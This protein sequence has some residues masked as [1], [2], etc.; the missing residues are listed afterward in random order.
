MLLLI[1]VVLCIVLVVIVGTWLSRSADILAEKTGLGR[2]LVGAIL[3][4]GVTSLPELATGISAV[5]VFNAPDLAAGGIFGSCLFNLF[6]LALLDIVTGPEP[7]FQRAH[8]SH[9]LAAGLGSILL[10]IAAAGMLLAQSNYNLT[11][12]WVGIPSIL[13]FVVYFQST[14]IIAQFERR[15]RAEVLEVEAEVFQYEH[16]KRQQAYLMFGLLSAAIV[17][18]GVWL[19]FLGDRV[20]AVTGLGESFI[21]ALLLAATTSLPEV[22]AGL[23]AIR[24]NAVDL[25]VSNIFGSNIFNMAILGVYDIAYFRGDLWSHISSVHIFTAIVALIMTSV[26]IVGLI[27]RAVRPSRLYISWDGLSL[28]ALYIGGM[29]IIYRS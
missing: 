1:Q 11:L 29:Y 10:G 3:L 16:I 6:I 26:A 28:I 18:L 5:A 21:G 22:V 25:A 13:L 7:L 9:G 4:A 2:T 19:A 27:Y 14:R 8:I 12:G 24:L 20:A 17:V 23:A 15:R